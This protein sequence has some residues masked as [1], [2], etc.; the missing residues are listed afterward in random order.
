MYFF[1]PVWADATARGQFHGLHEHRD[2]PPATRG[3]PGRADGAGRDAAT[4]G[5]QGQ[6]DRYHT[7]TAEKRGEG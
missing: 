4:S 3:E 5:R 7:D 6:P 2:I 1:C